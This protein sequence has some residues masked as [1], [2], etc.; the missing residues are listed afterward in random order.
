M[1]DHHIDRY[2]EGSAQRLFTRAFVEQVTR[3]SR[4]GHLSLG[5]NSWEQ[6]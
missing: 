1:V 3:L 2:G 6:S 4:L 5:Y